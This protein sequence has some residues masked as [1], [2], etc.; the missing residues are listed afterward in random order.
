MEKFKPEIILSAAISIDGKIATRS[1]DSK[2]SSK[3]DLKRLHKMRSQVDAIIVGKNT[4]E[5]DDPLLTVR[6]S[7]GKNPI[8]IILDSHGTISNK[9]KILKTSDKVKTIIVISKKISKINLNKL[10]QFPVEIIMSGEK[11]INLH[12]LIKNLKKRKIKKILVEGG[13]TTN[14][15]FL[16]NN[17]IDEFFITVTPHIIGGVNSISLIQGDGFAK[18][19]KSPKLKLIQVKRLGDDLVLHYRKL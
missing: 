9:S 12:I 10:K 11:K 7:K 5:K 16:K 4:V 19:I 18:L 3:K 13:G 1:G 2:L 14:W 8:R 6:Y 15:E 17:L